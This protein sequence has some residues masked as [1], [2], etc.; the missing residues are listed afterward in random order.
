MSFWFT[1]LLLKARRSV[2]HWILGLTGATIIKRWNVGE[3][4]RIVRQYHQ[5]IF[6]DH[7]I[8]KRYFPLPRLCCGY[9]QLLHVMHCYWLNLFNFS[10]FNPFTKG[11]V[12]INPASRSFSSQYEAWRFQSRQGVNYTY[13]LAL[14]P[15]SK[16][17]T[18]QNYTIYKCRVAHYSCS[19]DLE[20]SHLDI[21]TPVRLYF[22]WITFYLMCNCHR[23][24]QYFWITAVILPNW[25]FGFSFQVLSYD[26]TC[27][28]VWRKT[29]ILFDFHISKNQFVHAEMTHFW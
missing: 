29:D 7:Q 12:Y 3:Y 8:S 10:R 24:I 9:W 1:F 19:K 16:C 21:F 28:R 6:S 15:W 17:F 5:L 26:W 25:K 27:A 23:V 22:F 11:A 2:R 20:V 18:R 4:V 13:S 14:T